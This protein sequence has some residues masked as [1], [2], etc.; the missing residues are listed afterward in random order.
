MKKCRCPVY[1]L[2]AAV[3]M[4]SAVSAQ[5]PH[6]VERDWGAWRQDVLWLSFYFT[7][8]VQISIA[9]AHAPPPSGVGRRARA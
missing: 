9:L 7:R 5:A 8:A 6:P 2:G 3:S 1:A 4:A